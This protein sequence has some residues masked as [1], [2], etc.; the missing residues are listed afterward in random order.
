MRGRCERVDG[1]CTNDALVVSERWGDCEPP[2]S[3]SSARSVSR[4]QSMGACGS[5]GGIWR[6]GPG[7][8]GMVC[9]LACGAGAGLSSCRSAAACVGAGGAWEASAGVQ[10]SAGGGHCAP[11]CSP[12][13]VSRCRSSSAC[14]GAGGS[15]QMGVAAQGATTCVTACPDGGGDAGGECGLIGL[16]GCGGDGAGVCVEACSAWAAWRCESASACGGIGGTWKGGQCEAPC[17]AASDWEH[18]PTAEACARGG[19]TWRG[20]AVVPPGITGSI[21]VPVSG[22]GSEVLDWVEEAC[23]AGGYTGAI[24]VACEAVASSRSALAVPSSE[25]RWMVRGRAT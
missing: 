19:G 15:W 12:A 6:A 23:D 14:V 5:V 1:F 7:G 16:V 24:S 11:V 25:G 4:C 18:C 17:S 9:E 10:G 22:N 8:T 21:S 3:S 2:C 13:S 20:Y